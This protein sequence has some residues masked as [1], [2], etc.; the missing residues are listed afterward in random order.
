LLTYAH[1]FAYIHA[2]NLLI[3]SMISII[4]KKTNRLSMNDR[5]I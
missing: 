2:T 4:T 5:N 1:V 3:T